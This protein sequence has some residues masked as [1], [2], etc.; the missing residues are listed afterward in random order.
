VPG[1][2]RIA[3]GALAVAWLLAP[4]TAVRAAADDCGKSARRW[5]AVRLHGPG[6]SPELADSVFADLRAELAH[7]GLDACPADIQ[8]PRAPIVT[9]DIEATQ[10][11]VMHLS[12]DIT[13]PATDRPSARELRLDSIPIDGH[14]LA[15]AVAADELLTSSWIKLASRPLDAAAEPARPAPP[16]EVTGSATEA[17]RRPAAS[18]RHELAL[19]AAAERF[20]GG[21]WNPGIDLAIRRWLL[22][23]WALELTAGWR[24]LVDETA[25]HGR[26][27]SRAFPLSLRILAGVVPFATRVRAGAATAL[28]VTPLFFSAQPEPGAVGASQT[29]VAIYARG[30]LWADVAL[31][32]FRLRASAGAGVPL[33]SV[34]A[35]DAGVAV[36]GARGLDLHGQAGLVLEL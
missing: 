3:L 28:A 1:A 34:T 2:L 9:M 4:S 19:L 11:A 13:D 25:P 14:S 12:L 35:D 7:H 15:V 22:P 21:H 16:A 5:V 29:A 20:D 36:G 31:G 23:R 33:R 32:R 6:F 30:E 8:G 10:P 17:A 18:A 27:R 26:V 24:G